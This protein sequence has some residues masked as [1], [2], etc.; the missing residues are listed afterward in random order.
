MHEEQTP[1]ATPEGLRHFLSLHDEAVEAV[2]GRF[3][4]TVPASYE[5]FGERGRAACREDIGYHLEFLRPALEFGIL[6]PFVDYVRW[7]A[8]VL[9]TRGI[10]A[11]HLTLSL[12]WLTEFFAAR[13]P[14]E[15]A[16]P[17]VAALNAAMTALLDP[18][19]DV[20]PYERLMPEA[21]GECDAFEAALVRGDQRTMANI[22]R[23]VARQSQ[24]L[25]DTALHLVQPALH[26]IGRG[27]Q[28]NRISVAQEHLD[29]AARFGGEEFVVLMPETDTEHALQ[30]AERIRTRFG[31]ETIPPI[32]WPVTASFGVTTLEPDD[33]VMSLFK[34]ADNGLY[35]AK[36]AGRNR[37]VVA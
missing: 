25:L 19:D 11:N 37:V 20:P 4:L 29:L 14:D 26:R 36:D 23:E 33:T 28:D 17:V 31:Q 27:W 10:P 8:V 16:K 35:K 24:G 9:E 22:F 6:R 32:P 1:L 7:L 18:S 21:W 30:C 15:D 3:Y 2:V 13:L 34:R 5:K 12:S